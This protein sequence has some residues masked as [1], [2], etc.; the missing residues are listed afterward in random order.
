VFSRA[1]SAAPV[2]S[3]R[4]KRRTARP[5]HISL[6]VKINREKL[7]VIKKKMPNIVSAEWKLEMST[8]A[9]RTINPHRL[10][11]ETS[12]VVPNPE[13]K[14]ITLQLGDPT[15]F[16]NF[17]HPQEAVDALQKAVQKDAFSYYPTVGIKEARE[18][19]AEY[20]SKNSEPV[21]ADDIILTSGGSSALELC[22]Y[23]LANPG[24]NIL[25]PTP[26]FNYRTWLHGPGIVSK[27]YKLDPSR[28][29]EIDLKHLESQIDDK[30]RAILVNNVGNPC[31]NVFSR[32]HIM[33]ILEI[34]ERYRLPIISDDIYE[35]FV[36][37]GVEY[38]SVASLSKNVPILS[39][40]GLT[41][42]FIMPGIRMGWISIHD[43]HDALKE[44]KRGFVQLLGRNFGPNCTVQMA[45]P[46]ILKNVPQSFFDETVKKVQVHAITAFSLLKNVRGLLPI[47]P[48]GAFYMMIKIEL[49]SF[50]QFN[51]DVEFIDALTEEESVKAFPGPCFD[52]DG[53]FRFV[54]TVP[55]DLLVLACQRIQEFCDRH[56]FSRSGD[57]EV[58]T[59]A[60]S[61]EVAVIQNSFKSV[62]IKIC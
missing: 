39:C 9:R 2:I 53:Y 46:D 42:R 7:K 3:E 52:F 36:F 12:K 20:V 41:K 13:K 17:K 32:D 16:K 18:A 29:W 5:T 23:V 45:L 33:D 30:T 54:L 21:N 6:T 38:C 28:N 11:V 27:G 59:M 37:P 19:V 50:P 43:R 44:I 22:F 60:P 35:M 24:E 1:L 4:I 48:R 49:E 47:E 40:S 61:H 58:L 56:Y 31:G 26:S 8:F 51:S 25:I 10:M 57:A 14:V 34:A 55:L 62:E 15:I